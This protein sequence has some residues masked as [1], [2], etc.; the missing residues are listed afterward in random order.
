[1]SERRLIPRTRRF[2]VL[3]LPLGFQDLFPDELPLSEQSALVRSLPVTLEAHW[4]AWLGSILLEELHRAGCY[5]VTHS[6]SDVEIPSPEMA[7]RYFHIG[8]L[9]AL[10]H[11]SHQRGIRLTGANDLVEPSVRHFTIVD[12]VTALDGAPYS[13]IGIVEVDE[14]IRMAETLAFIDDGDR[15]R[16]LRTAARIYQDGLRAP[17]PQV[18]LHQFV[19]SFE[20]IAPLARGQGRP[21][22]G[23]RASDLFGQGADSTAQ[24]LYD[25]RSAEEHHNLVLPL[26]SGSTENDRIVSFM[27]LVY[28]SQLL[29][30]EALRRVLLNQKLRA[31]FE[32]DAAQ[33]SFWR[34][35]A[36]ERQALWGAQTDMVSLSQDFDSRHRGA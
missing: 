8:L 32:S 20:A 24:V 23:I 2:A 26:V 22:F 18:R 35:E 15:Y 29:A 33:D 12:P 6:S 16:R 30:R 3:A 5:F 10:K 36:G 34:L 25:L 17:S 11:P 27:R 14:A 1:M 9:L 13:R 31:H 21:E 7:S 19:R 4:E 28:Q